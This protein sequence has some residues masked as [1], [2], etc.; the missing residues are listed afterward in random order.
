MGVCGADARH[1]YVNTIAL[2][3]KNY[4]I[5]KKLLYVGYQT[6]DRSSY[7]GDDIGS[8]EKCLFMAIRVVENN[9]N[10]KN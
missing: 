10:K 4:N 2:I 6:L 9:T 7:T 5:P 1:N 8:G 3:E